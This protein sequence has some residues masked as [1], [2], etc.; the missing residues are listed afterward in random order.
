MM[1]EQDDFQGLLEQQ[2]RVNQVVEAEKAK[3]NQARINQILAEL[4][5]MRNNKELYYTREVTAKRTAL[6]KELTRLNRGG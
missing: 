5:E 4:R 1:S 6:H 2:E 3:R